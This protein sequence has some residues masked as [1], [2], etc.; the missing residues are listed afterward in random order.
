[1]TTTQSPRQSLDNPD[2]EKATEGTD[3]E[4]ITKETDSTETDTEDA[5]YP[6]AFPLALI[7][8]AVMFSVFLSALDQVS[9]SFNKDIRVRLTQ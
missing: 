4:T 6:S 1:M 3:T 8:M 5:E 9:L 7:T 2:V